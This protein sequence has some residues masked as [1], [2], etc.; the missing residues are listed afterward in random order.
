MF[1]CGPRELIG[2]GVCKQRPETRDVPLL[3]S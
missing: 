3:Q 1:L 2:D